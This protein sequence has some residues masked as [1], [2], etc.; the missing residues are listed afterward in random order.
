MKLTDFKVLAFGLAPEPN[1]TTT[2]SISNSI[3]S[4]DPPEARRVRRRR[5][6]DCRAGFGSATAASITAGTNIGPDS[7]DNVSGARRRR[8]RQ[9]N[10]CCGEIAW[11]RATSET[12][13]PGTSV[14][15]RIWAG[16][17]HSTAIGLSPR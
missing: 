2:P 7:G 5:L 11:R 4:L 14:S 9:P 6:A 8:R 12:T 1:H 16:H 10:N 17:R 3:P 13:A 15:S